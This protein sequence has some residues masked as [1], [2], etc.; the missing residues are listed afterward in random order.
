MQGTGNTD[1]INATKHDTKGHQQRETDI[2]VTNQRD[3]EMK[4]INA[5]ENDGKDFSRTER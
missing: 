3:N 2:M 4:V 1:I 5:R